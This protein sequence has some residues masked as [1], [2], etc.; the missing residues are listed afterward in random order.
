MSGNMSSYGGNEGLLS[1]QP[2]ENFTQ[3]LL[4]STSEFVPLT[5]PI[6]RKESV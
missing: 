6:S 3:K 5:E 2:V 1:S 4:R